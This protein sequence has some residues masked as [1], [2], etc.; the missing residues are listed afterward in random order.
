MVSTA[1]KAKEHFAGREFD[2][3]SLPPVAGSLPD[4]VSVAHD[5]LQRMTKISAHAESMK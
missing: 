5:T 1:I 2:F 4:D 3:S